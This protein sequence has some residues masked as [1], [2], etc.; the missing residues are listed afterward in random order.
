MVRVPLIFRGQ[1]IPATR[2][3]GA[4]VSLVDVVPTVLDLLALPA[5][6]GL[7]GRSLR[8]RW[9]NPGRMPP[10]RSL[11]FEADNI[12]PPQAPGPL[13]PGDVRA[14]RRGPFKLH[15]RLNT[16]QSEIFDLANDPTE[17]VDVSAEHPDVAAALRDELLAFLASGREPTE[18]KPLSAEDVERLRV[19]GYAAGEE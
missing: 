10:P 12:F 4:P 5:P 2:V 3:G 19:L 18:P 1:G 7:D 11:F 13:P 6:D 16:Q 14:V 8:P 15:Y 17:R 9:T